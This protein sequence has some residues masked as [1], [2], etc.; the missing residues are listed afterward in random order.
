[1]SYRYSTGNSQLD[2]SIQDILHRAGASSNPELLHQMM[3]TVV[4]LAQDGADTG[5]LK[6]INTTLK[7][8]RYAFKVM[9]PYRRVRKCAVFGSA[10]CKPDTSDYQQAQVFSKR[11]AD[12]GFMVITGAG[13][14]IM[15]A[16]NRGAGRECSFGLNIRLPFEQV[17]NPYIAGDEKLVNFKYFFTRKLAF[18]KDTHA[19]VCCPG[20]FGTHD[21]GLEVLTLIQTGKSHMVPIVFLHPEGSEFWTDWHKYNTDRLLKRGMI[22]PEDL[23]LYKV[24]S[25]VDEACQEI[26]AFYRRY[27][28]M[29]YVKDEL[30]VRLE[31]PLSDEEVE[32]LNEEFADLVK[33][34]SIEPTLALPQEADK[35]ISHLPRLKFHFARR[36]YG[37]LRQ[38]V[39]R[40]NSFD[41]PAHSSIEVPEAGAGGLLP[42]EMDEGESD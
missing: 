28:S 17:A 15:E 42:S 37:R 26:G 1:M 5:D 14:G 32:I 3:V 8:M 11:I 31:S 25:S 30:I 35:T 41:L 29:R 39:D 6:I 10:R 36:A 38:F 40:L 7:E 9:R 13:H 34:G 33:S 20:G 16:G 21:E 19:V 12:A 27:H 23:S 24:T 4:K 18:M 2:N 22:S